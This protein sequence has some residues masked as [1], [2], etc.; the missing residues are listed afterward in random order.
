MTNPLIILDRDGVINYE[1][2]AYIKSPAEWLPIPG[3][4][5]AIAQL[6]RAGYQVVVATNQSGIARGLYDL[7]MLSDIHAKFVSEL[8]AVG[9]YI[10]EIFF[11][12]HH[13]AV[14]CECRKPNLGLFRRIQEKYAT[15]LKDTFF[16]GDNF[17]DMQVAFA[18][19]CKPIL[20]LTGKGQKTLA[21]HPE[22]LAIPHFA[23]L[24]E[25]VQ[26][27]LT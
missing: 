2:A 11:C 26:Y 12:P 20:V 10:D 22:L 21:S 16:I 23:D 15:D 4:L 18:L 17:T 5:V 25:A 14:N 7:E 8:A 1:S 3:S 9:G 27:V 13:P 19:P 24:A 6:N